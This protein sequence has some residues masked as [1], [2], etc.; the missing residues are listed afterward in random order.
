MEP[1]RSADERFV[2]GAHS[3][4]SQRGMLTGLLLLHS[5]VR[6]ALLAVALVTLVRTSSSL[7]G[8]RAWSK[9]DDQFSVAL[10]GLGD[11]QLLVGLVVM[12]LSA[13]PKVAVSQ[14]LFSNETLTFFTLVHPLAMV[15]AIV[16]LHLGRVR[17]KRA[18]EGFA[19]HGLW[20]RT[21]AVFLGMAVLAI[22]WPW[23]AW[24]RP[25]MSLPWS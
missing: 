22:P 15:V 8:K 1:D 2:Q 18:P 5:L 13:L 10:V 7:S 17:L 3:D 24:G 21:T 20:R 19:R 14:G 23:L 16:L 12:G 4:V 9:E 25:L 6:W 11:L